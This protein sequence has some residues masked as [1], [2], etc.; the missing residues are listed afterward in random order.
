MTG[1]SP[2]I[3]AFHV[4]IGC[5]KLL[6]I[7]VG[8]QVT[9]GKHLICPWVSAL[10]NIASGRLPYMPLPNPPSPL[11][12]PVVAPPLFPPLFSPSLLPLPSPHPFSRPPP[13]APCSLTSAI[14][15]NSTGTTAANVFLLKNP[16]CMS[17]HIFCS[18]YT[19][20]LYLPTCCNYQLLHFSVASSVS[21][22]YLCVKTQSSATCQLVVDSVLC[23]FSV[24]IMRSGDC[25]QATLQEGCFQV[26]LLM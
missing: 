3:A 14:H 21:H 23:F 15:F 26:A 7:I 20:M 9:T 25:R 13:Y 16:A 12:P 18:S 17:L 24:V 11:A 4:P 19:Q 2:C 8:W 1:S 22:S 5:L 6:P 10:C